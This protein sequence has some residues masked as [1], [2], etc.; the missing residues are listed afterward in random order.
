M[1][2]TMVTTK[3]QIVIPSIMRRHF[4]IRKGTRL[5]IIEKEDEIVLKPL[6]REYFQKMAGILAVKGKS[7]TQELL[8]ERARERE[9]E[10]KKW[11]KF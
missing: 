9:A 4:N 7:M 10:D 8:E 5:C 3:G 6:T 2:M 1:T 11:S